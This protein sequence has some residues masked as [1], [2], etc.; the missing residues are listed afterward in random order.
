MKKLMSSGRSSGP[1]D[2]RIDK[3]TLAFDDPSFTVA[4]SR[5]SRIL[6]GEWWR[7]GMMRL[8][9]CARW[10]RRAAIVHETAAA[11]N[12]KAPCISTSSL[13]LASEGAAHGVAILR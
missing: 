6:P 11:N 1:P 8:G 10:G 4:K 13:K 5:R 3:E 9:G 7:R 12:G 2:P